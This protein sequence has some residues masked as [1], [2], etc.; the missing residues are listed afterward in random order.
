[1]GFYDIAADLEQKTIKTYK[2]LAEQCVTHEG[3]RN[4]LLMLARDQEKHAAKIEEIRNKTCEGIDD[5]NVFKEARRLFEEMQ[6]KRETFACDLDQLKL[7]RDA[8]DLLSEKKSLYT[9]MSQEA[10]CDEDRNLLLRLADEEKKQILVL[11]NIIEMVD[12]PNHWLEDA[13]FTHLEE[14]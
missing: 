12:R 7:Y 2:N 14:Y 6:R 4:I 11:D 10:D 3:V 5:T 9:K 1:M 13:E 8:R